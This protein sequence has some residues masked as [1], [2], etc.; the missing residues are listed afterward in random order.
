MMDIIIFLTLVD[1]Y[2]RG[3]WTF[4]LKTK[5]NAFP[6]LKS[7]MAMVERQFNLKVKRIRSDN[8]LEL[9]KRTQEAAFLSSQGI[10]HERSCVAT[11]QQNGVVKRKHK[12]L[13]KVAR[14]LLFQSY[15][16]VKF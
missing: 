4:L 13:L 12:Y 3:T 6:V 16:P 8:A 10:I 15:L 1:D 11:P 5:S 2:N 14:G 7:F 9:G